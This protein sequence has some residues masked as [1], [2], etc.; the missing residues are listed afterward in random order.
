M[1]WSITDR[2]VYGIRLFFPRRAKRV[3]INATYSSW[4]EILFGMRQESILGPLLFKIFLCDL[5]WI[6]CETNFASY[7]ND[8]TSYVLGDSMDDAI[9]SLEDDSINLF[10]W[11]LDNQMKANS[12]KYHLITSKQSWMN[13]KTGSIN[14]ESS[15]CEKLLGVIADNTTSMNPWME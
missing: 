1:L 8:N 14:I 13:L 12:V 5:F 4:E 2:F 9:K 6:M 11:Y 7:T 10:K 3:K 15:S